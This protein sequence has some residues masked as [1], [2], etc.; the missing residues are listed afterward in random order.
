M[1]LEQPT[2]EY[3]DLQNELAKSA[4]ERDSDYKILLK[5]QRVSGFLKEVVKTFRGSGLPDIIAKKGRE[6]YAIEVKT[7]RSYLLL[8][9]TKILELASRHGIKPY[10]LHMKI[11]VKVKE[12]NL[13]KMESYPRKRKS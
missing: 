2:V 1:K 3:F 7:G 6:I 5:D 4:I 12:A 11:D 9:Q 13:M 8:T 10:V